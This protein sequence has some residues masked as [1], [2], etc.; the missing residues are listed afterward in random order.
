[1]PDEQRLAGLSNDDFGEQV[2]VARDG[3]LSGLSLGDNR[4]QAEIEFQL[5]DGACLESRF[6]GFEVARA[7][8]R[9]GVQQRERQCEECSFNEWIVM[10]RHENAPCRL[11]D[12]ERGPKCSGRSGL[13]SAERLE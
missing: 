3:H 9:A 7:L 2:V 6:D 12:K 5:R 8:D 13:R 1:K 11:S 4:L 10:N